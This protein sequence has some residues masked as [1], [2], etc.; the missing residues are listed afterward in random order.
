MVALVCVIL[1]GGGVLVVHRGRG[2]GARPC[3]VERSLPNNLD[4]GAK[5]P[6]NA[7]TVSS[8]PLLLR[9]TIMDD[10]LRIPEVLRLIYD[11]LD[12]R[13]SLSL[14][15]TCKAFLEPG[16]DRIWRNI[17]SFKPLMACIAEDI[18]RQE[19]MSV[20]KKLGFNIFMV[21]ARFSVQQNS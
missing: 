9:T 13:T 2:E 16:L 1:I 17:T 8:I 6:V 19:V 14:A 12:K 11:E 15:L 3:H 7:T 5:Q 4:A 21:C 20:P 10:C 18:W